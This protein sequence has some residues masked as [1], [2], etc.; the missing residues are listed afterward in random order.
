MDSPRL[1]ICFLFILNFLVSLTT[2][3]PLRRNLCSDSGNYTTNS[4]YARN[5]NAL[6]SS[7]PASSDLD[8]D[9][10]FNASIGQNPNQVYAIGLCRGY[11]AV[12]SCR[13]CLNN[14]V[15]A[16]TQAC[17]NQK[18][19][20]RWY[21][22][23]ML[24]FSNRNILSTM[25]Q[26]FVYIGWYTGNA[27]KTQWPDVVG[28]L[29]ARLR[30]RAAAGGVR[31][32]AADA[33]IYTSPMKI[34]AVEQCTPDISVMECGRCL[35]TAMTDVSAHCNGT[36][37]LQNG[38]EIAVKRL[39]SDSGQDPAKR[40]QLDWDRRYKIIGGVAR[41]LLYLHEDSRLRIIHRDLKASNVLLDEEMNPKIADF[42]MAR[43]FELDETQGDTSRIVGTYGYMAP[44]YAMHGQF[45]VKSDVF[46]FGVLVLEIVSG[47][48]NSC[49]RIGENVEDLL[50]YA[51]KHWGEGTGSN[52]I[53]LVL[54]ADSGSI[55]DII[56]C[57]HIGLLCVQENVA[58]RPTMAS[59]VLM[60]NSF[61][62]T[63]P[64]PSEPAFFMHS[65]IDPEFPLLHEYSSGAKDSGQSTSKSAHFSENEASISELHPR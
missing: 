32:Y 43:L 8:S 42:G 1:C 17:P 37:S 40:G 25:D 4:T 38:Q 36:G 55:R 7:I 27:N 21:E 34:Y 3:Q 63:L 61:S 47:Q 10:F 60:L 14:S 56:R 57:I 62:I 35:D 2:P 33:T 11:L 18:E 19:A 9:G 53:D 24:R 64:L 12:D 49:F 41:G 39:S 15:Q 22:D 30:D 29:L 26:S 58:S 23:C 44:E 13:S 6:L 5:L 59:V 31:K 65:S 45:S 52:L 51:W 16:I 20:G 46:S 48:K 28:N 54:R 50:S